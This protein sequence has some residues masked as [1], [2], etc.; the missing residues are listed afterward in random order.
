MTSG[1][2]EP[3]I[4]RSLGYYA[5]LK[6]FAATDKRQAADL[7]VDTAERRLRRAQRLPCPSVRKCKAKPP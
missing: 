7:M 6:R 2:W 4:W 1:P 5:L 3:S